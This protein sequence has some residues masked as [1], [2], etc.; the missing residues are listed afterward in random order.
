MSS[1]APDIHQAATTVARPDFRRS[2]GRAAEP[3]PSDRATNSGARDG[4]ICCAIARAVWESRCGV[5]RLPEGRAVPILSPPSLTNL[6]RRSDR[7]YRST[8]GRPAWPPSRHSR[9]S[10]S[11][12]PRPAP[13]KCRANRHWW[14]SR[15]PAAR[16]WYRGRSGPAPQQSLPRKAKLTRTQKD[17]IFDASEISAKLPPGQHSKIPAVPACKRIGFTLL[18][19]QCGD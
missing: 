15:Q 16:C 5:D 12:T 2:N 11:S 18:F 3:V 7:N 8:D 13:M 14:W 19:L 10:L 17:R 1:R 4:Q 6:R 9:L